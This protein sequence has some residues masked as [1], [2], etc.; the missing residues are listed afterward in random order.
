MTDA[1][2]QRLALANGFKLKEQVGGFAAL[3]P[4]VFAFAR[5]L[6]ASKEL[7]PLHNANL[8]NLCG[9]HLSHDEVASKV[10]M[11]RRTDLDHEP[12]CTMA[13]DRI[14]WLA[15]RV[16]ELQQDAERYRRLRY[17]NSLPAGEGMGL[18]VC[19][20]VREVTGVVEDDVWVGI[21]LDAVIDVTFE[22]TKETI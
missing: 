22:K 4:Y 16:D 6:L 19:I 10:R 14:K 15:N 8:E 3:N 13:R 9:G 12:V 7:T 5:A 1:E 21:A 17:E 18:S 2:I 20:E 11:L